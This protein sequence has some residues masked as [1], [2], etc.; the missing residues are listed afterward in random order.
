[1]MHIRNARNSSRA[2]RYRRESCGRPPPE[3]SPSRRA[4]IGSREVVALVEQRRALHLRAGVGEAIAEVQ[5]GGVAGFAVSVIGVDGETAGFGVD[6]D[7]LD[8][9]Q[10]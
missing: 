5:G 6:G 10:P 4:Y 8:A 2:L 9:H 3:S 1:M 7:D